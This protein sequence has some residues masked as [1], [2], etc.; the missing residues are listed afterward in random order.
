[1]ALTNAQLVTLKAALLAETDAGVVAARAIRNDVALTTWC[2]SNSAQAAWNN[3][4]SKRDL[5]EATDITKFDNL[6]AGKRDAQSRLEDN[7]PLDFSRLKAR[8][9]VVDIW[10]TTDSVAILTDLTRFATR[11]EVYLGGTSATTNT[12]TALKL[13]VPGQVSMNDVSNALNLP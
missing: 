9:A 1:M 11:A 6:T 2:N 8:K 7:A 5:F 10:G 3:N 13:N 12:V 4:V